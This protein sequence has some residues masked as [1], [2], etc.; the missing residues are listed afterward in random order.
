[1]SVDRAVRRYE[2]DYQKFYREKVNM[3]RI[4]P[5]KFD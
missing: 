5:I 2:L 4:E 3:T 1:M